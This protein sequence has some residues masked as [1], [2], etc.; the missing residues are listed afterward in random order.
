MTEPCLPSLSFGGCVP[1][2]PEKLQGQDRGFC[3]FFFFHFSLMM[4]GLSL[5]GH[6]I[7][8]SALSFPLALFL[9]P[10]C[11]CRSGRM[12]AEQSPITGRQEWPRASAEHGSIIDLRFPHGPFLSFAFWDYSNDL[13]VLCLCRASKGSV[14]VEHQGSC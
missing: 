9:Q 12:L 7:V 2:C 5:W 11:S 13:F 8:G 1:P 6:E 4:V 10:S 3:R 14:D